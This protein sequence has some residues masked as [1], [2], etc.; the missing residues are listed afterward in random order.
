MKNVAVIGL[1]KSGVAAMKLLIHKGYNVFVYDD[2]EAQLY[3]YINIFNVGILTSDNMEALD[4]AVVS[5]G[6]ADDNKIIIELSEKKVKIISELELGYL[7]TESDIIAVTGTNGKTSTTTLVSDFLNLSYINAYPLGNIGSPLCEKVETLVKSDVAVIEASSFQL[8]YTDK[9]K[10]H[11]AIILNVT[12]DHIDRH[13]TFEDYIKSKIRITANQTSEDYAVLNYE[14]KILKLTENIASRKIYF[15]S[16]LILDNGY[17]VK[18]NKIYFACDKKETFVCDKSETDNT[19]IDNALALLAVCGI[20][21]LPYAVAVNT[22]KKFKPAKYTVEKIYDR[23]DL[24]IFNDSKGT[25]TAATITAVNKMRGETVL[26]MGGR[27]KGEKYADFFKTVKDK[28]KHFVF[29][30]EN[31]ESLRDTALEIGVNRFTTCK[32]LEDA[33]I[34]ANSEISVGNILFSPACASFDQYRN[35]A[36]RGNAF[37]KIVKKYY[38]E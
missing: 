22:I 28:I 12:N 25:N 36:D 34:A 21:K 19:C 8:K 24:R 31:A 35:Y 20:L 9:F 27:E 37:E 1:G 6:V 29:F 5:P 32:T 16:N 13:K 30:G 15:S 3:K 10:P 7:Y 23:N 26:I 14:E 11:I 33:F 17:Y 18:D 2:N 4:F 38:E